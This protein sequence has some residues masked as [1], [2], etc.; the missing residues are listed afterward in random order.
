[1][2]VSNS[3]KEKKVEKK[4]T[5][6]EKG[7]KVEK[8]DTENKKGKK[9]EKKDAKSKKAKPLRR[10]DRLVLRIFG[11]VPAELELCYLT[12]LLSSIRRFRACD[13][14]VDIPTTLKEE[15]L[16]NKAPPDCPN[17][18]EDIESHFSD[19]D[20]ESSTSH[21]LQKDLAESRITIPTLNDS[22]QRACDAFLSD[23]GANIRIVQGYVCN[24]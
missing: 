22:Q 2:Q 13:S 12:T 14:L 3:K 4:D 6:N 23:R 7:K 17:E 15:L 21:R 8:K 18:V 11:D 5:E 24:F 16:G 1:M 19:V 9:V 10:G 20:S